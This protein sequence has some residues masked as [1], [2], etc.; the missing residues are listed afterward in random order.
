MNAL[1]AWLAHAWVKPCVFV[2]A[3]MPSIWLLVAALTDRLGANP[4]EA[5]ERATGLWA[6]RM[7]CIVLAITPLRVTFQLP[8]LARWRRMLG[9]FVFYYA[10][11]H[12]SAY[13]VFDMGLDWGDIVADIPK[14]P[15]VLV[16]VLALTFLAALAATSFNRAIRWLG[17]RRWQ[18]LH[19]M[20]Y[21]V[22][23]LAILHFFWMRAG[24]NNFADVVLYGAILAGLVGWRLRRL[25]EGG[26]WGLG[27]KYKEPV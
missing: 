27:G 21:A 20:V 16:G 13:A 5:L 25:L 17:G 1:R 2:L 26:A 22:A 12:A 6:L 14:R 23:V 18:W 3:L 7:L 8:V 15:F 4:A 10:V 11:L 9:L 24:K 19:R